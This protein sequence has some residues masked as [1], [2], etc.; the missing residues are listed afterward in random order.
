M[1]VCINLVC[2]LWQNGFSVNEG[3]LREYTDP[4]N[5]EFLQSIRRGEIPHELR[6]GRAEVST[7]LDKFRNQYTIFSDPFGNGR[8]SNGTI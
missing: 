8:S 5:T 1:S 6:Q 3:E 7:F 4:S 2:R